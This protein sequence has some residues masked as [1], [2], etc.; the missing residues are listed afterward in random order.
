MRTVR[1]FMCHGWGPLGRKLQEGD[2]HAESFLG[3]ALCFK[4]YGRK[5]KEVGLGRTRNWASIVPM[6]VLKLRG[7]FTIVPGL[8][9]RLGP[10]YLWL[11]RGCNLRLHSSP[12]QRQFFEGDQQLRAVR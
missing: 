12:Q 7:S 8:G 5:E 4:T 11:G 9:E 1:S 3:C 2:P 10:S 6:G